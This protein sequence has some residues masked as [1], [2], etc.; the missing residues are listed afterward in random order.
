MVQVW[1][2]TMLIMLLLVPP[3]VIYILIMF[4][5]Y[6]VLPK[7]SYMFTVFSTDNTV[8][9][10]Y[11]L[12]RFLIKDLDTRRVLLQ[13]PC[14]DGLYPI[15]R[16]WRQVFGV[17]KPSLQVWHKHLGHPSFHIVTKLVKSN[18]LLCSSPSGS[19]SQHVCDSCQQVK[20]HQLPY[21]VYTT[22]SS[23]PLQLVFSDVWGL[24]PDSVERKKYYVSFID[25]FSKCTWVYLLR[26]KS[27]VLQKFTEF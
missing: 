8:L 9:L 11:F 6:Q 21:P 20:S 16:A 5:M 25:D 22:V 18:K 12:D 3:L 15:P 4:F 24:A 17:F 27:E 23:K 14:R 10:E 26:F 2:F 1:T 7:I 13:G 19:N